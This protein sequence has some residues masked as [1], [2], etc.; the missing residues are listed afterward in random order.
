MLDKSS[1]ASNQYTLPMM[2]FVYG[3]EMAKTTAA[4][5]KWKLASNEFIPCGACALAKEK[6]KAVPKSIEV[7]ATKCGERLF[8]D[9]SGPYTKSI[10]GSEYWLLVVDDSSKKKWSC[11]LKKK[12]E[13]GKQLAPL[14][15]QLETSD[16]KCSFIFAATT[17]AK[18]RSSFKS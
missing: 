12:S 13:I 2:L 14:L 9:I 1:I 18:T 15:L 11:F 16:R 4:V 6:A 17:R 7:K 10:T 5:T 3:T 8:I